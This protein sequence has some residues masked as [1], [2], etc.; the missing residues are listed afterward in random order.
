MTIDISA[1]NPRISYSVASGVTQTSFTVPF[2]FFDDSDLNVYIDTTLQ[3]ITTHYT[4]A[5]GAGSTGTITMSVTGPK[6]VI[7]TRDTTIERTTDFTAGVDI[8]RA[9]LNTQLDTLTAISADNKDFAE[10]S[11]RIVDYDPATANLLLPDAATRADKL[12]SF[13][14]EGDVSVQAAADLL[15]GSVLGANYTKASYTGDGTQTAYSTVESAGSK[16]NIQVYVDGVYQNKATF[17]ISGAT[18]TFTEAPPLNS[19][20][21]FIVGN[22]VTSLTTDPAVVNYNQ[23]GTGAQ[24]RTLT[25]KLQ[26]TVSVKDFGAVGNGVADDTAAIQAAFDLLA[27]GTISGVYFPTGDYFVSPASGTTCFQFSTPTTDFQV[28]P[29][30]YLIYGDGNG[31]RILIDNAAADNVFIA[32]PAL[33][34]ATDFIDNLTF[35]D[36]RIESKTV[37]GLS[38]YA[39]MTNYGR[40]FNVARIRRSQFENIT[41]YGVQPFFQKTSG[42]DSNNTYVQQI[43]IRGCS[44]VGHQSGFVNWESPAYSSTIENNNIEAGNLGIKIGTSSGQSSFQLNILNNTI[45]SN[46]GTWCGLRL[47]WTSACSI[48]GNYFESNRASASV[49]TQAIVI[50]NNTNSSSLVIDSNLFSQSVTSVNGYSSPFY[51][52][53]LDE[54]NDTILLRGNTFTGGNGVELTDTSTGHLVVINSRMNVVGSIYSEGD[55]V[56][57][58]ATGA[59]SSTE[60]P[61][62][63]PRT[64]WTPVVSDAATGGNLATA[65]IS[66]ASY[67]RLGN[68]V[69]ITAQIA[70]INTAGMTGTNTIYIQGLPYS[71]A[72]SSYNPGSVILEQVTFTGYVNAHISGSS[73]TVALRQSQ[74]AGN[75]LNLTVAALSSGSADIQFSITY[76]I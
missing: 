12:L 25:S 51:H 5:G 3:T 68:T 40:A 13:D 39:T 38:R 53:R 35:R 71:S 19:A 49:A 63:V 67:T 6:T 14:T 18:L 26:D 65:S 28:N 15:T 58:G 72:A 33:T 29:I 69:T 52:V 36:M 9:A 54:V 76:L 16:N 8:N 37:A 7:L 55:V 41:F 66:N 70:N 1:N 57:T 11:I 62:F 31:S 30:G 22:A 4:V 10:R 60:L 46:G 64:T 74:S 23:G 59:T 47:N 43:R 21:E 61:T 2:E 48:I 45:Q 56:T 17:S 20:I 42:E 34:G 32:G 44:S 75:D 50:Q 73:D 27:V 24:D